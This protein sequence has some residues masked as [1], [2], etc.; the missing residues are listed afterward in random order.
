M[1]DRETIIKALERTAPLYAEDLAFIIF[2]G[3][4][5][6]KDYF[7][8]LRELEKEGVIVYTNKNKIALAG[9]LGYF[10]G[11]F[12]FSG[13]MGVIKTDEKE[14]T[15][16]LSAFNGALPKDT[17]LAKLSK[18]GEFSEVVK[19]LKRGEAF[20]IGTITRK[21]KFFEFSGK[22][23][24]PMKVIIPFSNALNAKNNDKVRIIVTGVAKTGGYIAKIEKVYGNSKEPSSN[25]EAVLDA[26]GIRTVFTSEAEEFAKTMASEKINDKVIAKRLDLRNK[27]IFTIDPAD[28]KDLDDAV[29]IEKTETGYTLGVH[30]ADVSHYVSEGSALD[31]EAFLR[32]TSV[33]FA[34]KV[35]PMLPEEIS[36]GACSLNDKEDKLTLSVIMHLDN[37]GDVKDYEIKESIISSAKKCSYSDINQIINKTANEALTKAYA[38]VLPYIED[39]LNLS[40]ILKKRRLERGAIDFEMNEAK[41]ILDEN[42]TPV[43]I[44]KRIRGESERIIEEFMLTANETTARF[45]FWQSLPYVYRIHEKPDE[46]KINN[47]Y[48][49]IRNLGFNT[50]NTAN[51]MHPKELQRILEHFKDT[52]YEPIV[53]ML[54]LRSLAK[55]KYSTNCLGHFGLNLEYYCH[56]TSPI[57][58]YPDLMCHR[59]I[60]NIVNNQ[61]T[62]KRRIS[63]ESLCSNAASQSSLTEVKAVNAE[64][65]IEDMYKAWYMSFRLGKTFDGIISSVTSFGFY[66]EFDNTI[67]GLVRVADIEDDY[68]VFEQDSLRL[69]GERTGRQF[70][71]GDEIKVKCAAADIS[72]GQIDFIIENEKL[73]MKK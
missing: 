46:V 12:A 63:L 58:R 53:S 25:Y 35:V 51:G 68:Y 65:G 9:K 66:V 20:F 41:V 13:N 4:K 16:P 71:I 30:I 55:A 18:R 52:K 33:Y 64:R 36:N 27:V 37:L 31:R 3:N 50:K 48:K 72:T 26:N 24:F 59:V 8:I 34:D 73:K 15:V 61:M 28:A 60:K 7:D 57:R 11:V 22:P 40:A 2:G 14:I 1:T 39:M 44:Q 49:I 43:D 29:S 38:P 47:L 70:N 62:E 45:V 42:G 6:D 67:E 23:R 17:V 19:I 5:Y 69:I 21:D 10:S 56:F 54:S 32:G